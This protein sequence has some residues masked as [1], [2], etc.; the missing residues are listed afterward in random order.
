MR[1]LASKPAVAA[2]CDQVVAPVQEECGQ[3]STE[4]GEQ[5]PEAIEGHPQLDGRASS[6]QLGTIGTLDHHAVGQGRQLAEGLGGRLALKRGILKARA[7]RIACQQELDG[8]VAQSAAA[9][10]EHCD[11]GGPRARV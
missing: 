9:V 11:Q 8:P 4:G 2:S 1:V 10:V 7:L 6:R 3:E 5:P